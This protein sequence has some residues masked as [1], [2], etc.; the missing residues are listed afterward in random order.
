MT[1]TP[2]MLQKQLADLRKANNVTLPKDDSRAFM[3][4]AVASAATLKKLYFYPAKAPEGQIDVL[5]VKKRRMKLHQGVNTVP[6]GTDI[7]EER[8][9]PFLL[10]KVFTDMWL[11][12]ENIYYTAQSR[13]D[14]VSDTIVSMLRDQ[15]SADMQDLAFN[16]DKASAVDFL[17]MKDGYLKLARTNADTIKHDVTGDIKVMDLQA[18]PP[19]VAPEQL[20]VGNYVWI[21]G[22]GTHT[23]LQ[24]EV[25]ARET[26]KGDAVLVDGELAKLHGYSIE[27]VDHIEEDVVLFTPLE[28]LTVVTGYEVKYTRATPS[29]FAVAKE[30]TYHYLSASVDF[31]IRTPKALVYIGADA[32]TP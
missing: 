5:G 3:R 30:S 21:M 29:E 16:G 23:K 19:T 26:A 24:A 15:F 20:R 18:V 22:R 32:V 31:L 28:N 11:E 25:I 10:T 2:E 6:N 7:V 14:N 13:G 1:T 4:D 12:D 17:K 9:V 8:V 27:L